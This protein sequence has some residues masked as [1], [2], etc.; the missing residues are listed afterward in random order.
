MKS[1]C[2]NDWVKAGAY[3][4][5]KGNFEKAVEAYAQARLALLCEMGEC[6]VSAGQLAEGTVLFEEVLEANPAEQRANAGMG[7][8]SLLTGDMPKAEQAFGNVLHVDPG[9]VKGLCGLALAYK[10]QNKLVEA[11]GLLQQA[12][13]H[14]PYEKT[15]VQAFAELSMSLGRNSEALPV[16]RRYLKRHPDDAELS[17]DLKVLEQAVGDCA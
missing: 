10:G 11:L 2:L 6:L 9:H 14:D 3:Y 1:H 8:V 16:L 13:E 17:S 12:L 4:R 7:I 5:S 15:A